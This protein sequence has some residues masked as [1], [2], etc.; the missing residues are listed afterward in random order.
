M[1]T[2]FEAFFWTTLVL[3]SSSFGSPAGKNCWGEQLV[4]PWF[5]VLTFRSVCLFQRGLWV[6]PPLLA[7][8]SLGR[9][10]KFSPN[11]NSQGFFGCQSRWF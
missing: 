3:V 8:R 9:K 1:W 5:C 6:N 4:A 2:P 10:P 11:F 7:T